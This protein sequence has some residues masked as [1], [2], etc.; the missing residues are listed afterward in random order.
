[1]LTFKN[2]KI[3]TSS[4]TPCVSFHCFYA[5]TKYTTG[6]AA[7]HCALCAFWHSWSDFCRDGVSDIGW[8]VRFTK[9]HWQMGDR[10]DRHKYNQTEISGGPMEWQTNRQ[11]YS[12]IQTIRTKRQ[13]QDLSKSSARALGKLNA[14]MVDATKRI[15]QAWAFASFAGQQR[16]AYLNHENIANERSVAQELEFLWLGDSSG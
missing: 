11:T 16:I 10:V 4:S 14:Y 7:S 12:C 2:N 15:W 3:S 13:P 5:A 9:K 8:I 1:M 6:T